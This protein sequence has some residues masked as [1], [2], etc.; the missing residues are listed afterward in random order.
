MLIHYNKYIAVALIRVDWWHKYNS[1]NSF[2]NTTQHF[3]STLQIT[4][5]QL[6]SMSSFNVQIPMTPPS[7][8]PYAI[9]SPHMYTPNALLP[10]IPANSNNNNSNNITPNYFNNNNAHKSHVQHQ[11]PSSIN[12]VSSVYYPAI[13]TT[14]TNN[15]NNT[16]NTITQS[17]HTTFNHTSSNSQ[18][19][20]ISPSV[21][22][23][24]KSVDTPSTPSL[25]PAVVLMNLKPRGQKHPKHYW[26]DICTKGMQI[27]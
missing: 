1:N 23:N 16:L 18:Q 17:P 8:S 20:M 2:N 22:T 3:N 10:S 15:N 14:P 26:C 7:H 9:S 4:T 11:F 27:S 19:H 13:P 12:P 24:H 21:T 6:L 5:I 25:D